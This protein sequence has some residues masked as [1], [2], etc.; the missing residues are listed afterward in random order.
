MSGLHVCECW[1]PGFVKYFV[2]GVSGSV[3]WQVT[4]SVR[5]EHVRKLKSEDIVPFNFRKIPRLCD[6]LETY[7][8]FRTNFREFQGNRLSPSSCPSTGNCFMDVQVGKQ[9]ASKVSPR[10]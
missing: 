3:S 10:Y 5:A 7:P 1:C 4:K 9:T 6:D 2:R 8:H